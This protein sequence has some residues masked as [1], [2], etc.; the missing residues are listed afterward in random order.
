ME[1]WILK[2]PKNDF[3][4][5]SRSLGVSELICRILTNRGIRDYDT[6]KRF[7][8]PDMEELFDGRAMKDLEKGVLIIKD[9][10]DS[11]KRIR[12]IGDYD[13]DGVIS[14]YI[15]FK[16][17]T[18]CGA[19]ADYVIPHRIFD[20]YGINNGIIETAKKDGIDTIITCDNGISA[21]EQISFAKKEGLTVIVTDHHD[22]PF[23]EDDSSNRIQAAPDADA[24]IDMKQA[25]C[26]YPFKL[27]CGAG[28]AFKFIQ[29]LYREMNIPEKEE[30]AFYEFLAIATVCDVVDLTGE[31]RILVKNGLRAISNTGNI[32]LNAL[33]EQTGIKGKEIGV[34]HLGFIIGPC[35]NASGRLDCA[36]KGLELLL[37]TDSGEAARRARELYCLNTERK[38]M[39]LAGVEEAV[40]AIENSSLKNDRV[41]VV[42]RP[43][44]HES[45]AGIIAGKI[46]ER[47]NAPAFILTD[48]ESCVKG[49]GRSID[50]YNMFEELQKCKELLTRF[51][52]HPLAAGFSLE[53]CNVEALR[54]QLNN[55]SALTEDDL[56][57]K[58][59]IDAQIP[60]S[61]V[62]LATAEALKIL[63]PY[64]KGNSK[65]VFADK[66]I[67]V[68]RAAVLGANKN[69]LKLRLLSEGKYIDC[70]YFGDIQEFDDYLKERFGE[71][72]V[73]SMYS[74]QKNNIRLDLTFNIDVN[75]YNGYRNAQLILLNYR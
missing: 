63:E 57:Q 24:V 21:I 56:I 31:N 68:K 28:V 20:G 19:K 54:M 62:N 18:A 26:K 10:I 5:M 59:Y 25:D 64:G 42:Y 49:S 55:Y 1:K 71:E 52:G 3:N 14:T 53:P 4:K 2:N 38:N 27:L 61:A 47:Y 7:I 70:I 29:V 34:Y 44:I 51:G 37:C 36:I 22:V 6:A 17:L 13:V 40:A 33:M 15:L 66:N 23:T 35:I 43:D 16:A 67:S 60:V 72:E 9:K 32:G 39:T 45:I 74:G 11:G 58:V 50:A 75:E 46:R 12:I 73:S 8:K 48:G 41:L 30:T 69:V 65:P